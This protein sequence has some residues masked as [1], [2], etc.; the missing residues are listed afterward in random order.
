M[1][2]LSP[3]AEKFLTDIPCASESTRLNRC[4]FIAGGPIYWYK[5]KAMCQNLSKFKAAKTF[6]L[7]ILLLGIYFTYL[8][9]NI[10]DII[11][12]FMITL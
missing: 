10:Y 9:D 11:M 8:Y 5:P 3:L 4:S 12:I 1:R 2:Y 7:A 6:D